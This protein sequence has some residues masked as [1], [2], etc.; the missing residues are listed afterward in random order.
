MSSIDTRYQS[1]LKTDRFNVFFN[2]THDKGWNYIM[3]YSSLQF[4]VK[5]MADANSDMIVG[6]ELKS[7][8]Y[9]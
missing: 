2:S 3:Y 4:L 7:R 8:N 5:E 6:V 9:R 1:V